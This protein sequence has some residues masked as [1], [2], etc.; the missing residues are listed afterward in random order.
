MTIGKAIRKILKVLARPVKADR[1]RGGVVICPYRGY[2]SRKETFLMGRVFRQPRSNAAADEGTAARDLI[3]LGRRFLRRGLGNA[4]LTARFDGVEQRVATD[5]DGYFRVHLK[6]PQ[7]P[8][9]DRLWHT[10]ALDLVEPKHARARVDGEVFIPP[11]RA[12]Y[13]VISDIDDTVMYTGVANK[14][15]MMWRLFVQGAESRVAFPGVAAFYR[16][17]HHGAAGNELN[18]MLYVSRGPWSIYE[19]LDAFFDLHAIPVGPIL[20]LREWGLTLQRPLPR[21]AKDHKINL[22]RNMLALYCDLPFILVGDS[23]QHDPELYAQVVREHPGRVVAIYIRNVTRDA[24]RSREIEDLAKEVV[25]QGSSLLLASDSFTMARHAYE[26]GLI[27]PDGLSA[28]LEEK[29]EDERKERREPPLAKKAPTAGTAADSDAEEVH[30]PTRDETERAVERGDLRQALDR[31]TDEDTPPE[32]AV[33]ADEDRAGSPPA[34][35]TH[36]GQT[37]AG[38]TGE[39]Q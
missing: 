30:R 20:F 35:R 37:H 38:R 6:L 33:E 1:G 39:R 24:R 22:V 29:E 7:P 28:V 2:G 9:A 36:A 23:G 31:Q 17:L 10:I 8:T 5:R 4:I 16:A 34:G 18:P 19:V 26:H 13:V 3:D 11:E 12:R 32:V 25:D 15:M 21:K 27:S 14:T